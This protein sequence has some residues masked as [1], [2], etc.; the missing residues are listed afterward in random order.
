MSLSIPS[1]HTKPVFKFSLL[2]V[3]LIQAQYAIANEENTQTAVM[4]TIKIEAMSELD[5]IKSYIDYEQ[6]SVTRNGLK[7]KDIPQTID[8]IDVQ[9]Y[10]I[11]GANDLSVM[12]QGTPGVSTSYDMRGDGISLRGFNADTGDIYRDGI[13]ESGQV[14]RSTANVERIEILKGPASVLYGRSSGG[15][16]I[17]MVSKVANFDSKSS[18]GIYGGSYDNYGSIVDL[19]QIL[20]D[21][22]AVRLTGEYGESNSFRSGIENKIEMLSPSFT[23]KNDDGLTWTMQYTYDKLH[24]V[25]DRGPEFS[26]LP[27]GTSIKTGFAQKGD[28]VNDLLQIARSDLNYE[29]APNWNFHWA[30]SHRQAEQNFDHFYSG[31]YCQTDQ[32]VAKN[33]GSCDGHA[34]EISQIY[35]W[36]QTSNKTTSN[37]FDIRGEFDTGR[38]KHNLLVGADWTYEQR[39]P[40]L[41]NK[42]QDGSIL[43][44]YVNPLTGERSNSR[45]RSD[46]KLNT[47]NYNQSEAYGLFIQDLI[48]FNDY[49]KVMLG[50]RYDYF[51]SKTTNRLKD[52]N[53]PDYQR[54]IDGESFSPNIGLIWQ[55][56]ESQSFYASYSKSFA[57]FG[58]SVG[59]NVVSA[60]TNLDAFDAEPQYNEQYEVGV[61]SDWINDRLNTQLSVFDIRKN[62]IRYKPNPDDEPNVWAVGG[63]HRSRGVEFSFIGRV[64][65]NLFVRGGYGYNEAEVTKD[66]EK[67][68]NI[69]KVLNNVPKHTGNLFVRY[70][71]TDKIYTEVG[72]TYVGDA[73]VYARGNLDNDP[74]SFDGFTRVD[75]AIGYSADPWNVTIAVNNLTNKEYWRSASMPGTPRNFLVRLNYQF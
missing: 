37:S 3:M 56:I 14:R 10:K 24:R 36:Q 25:P 16:V 65:D 15:G 12:L 44:G 75:A 70:L 69:G 30:L 40:K 6:A 57:P 49:F 26:E 54:S 19:N 41:A 13:R 28:Y 22:V 45:D 60:N 74:M 39:E 21:N 27:K 29:F 62:N 2:T 34:G 59:V 43:W 32:T 18:V 5:P 72:A 48:S 35:Y 66:K 58:G 1:A 50:G 4:P 46:L 47:H 61:K 64:L 38:L 63:Q 42:N 55:P 33:I 68:Q 53:D 51:H 9:K 23:Y 67:P 11:Y 20:T 17:N 8:T 52:S 71:P 73:T 31:T 7:K